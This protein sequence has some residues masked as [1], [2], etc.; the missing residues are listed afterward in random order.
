MRVMLASKALVVGAYHRKL[1]EI[2]SFPGIELIAVVPP[3]WRDPAYEQ[4]LERTAPM[5]YE[6]VVTPIAWNGNF[7]LF[8]YPRLGRLLTEYRPDIL[9]FDEE[10]YNLATFLALAQAR[11]R[12][13]PALF[14][15]WQNLNRRYP[16]PFAWM[17][18]FA[19]RTSSWAIAGTASAKRVL[20]TKGYRGPLTV[21]PQFGIDP[22]MYR[23]REGDPASPVLRIGFAGRLVVEKGVDLLVDAVAQMEQPSRLDI[24]GEGPAR[25]TIEERIRAHNLHDRIRLAGAVPSVE[26][27]RRLQELDVVVLPSISRPNW[28]EQFGRILVEAMASGLAVVGSTC[29]EI[30]EVIGDA[31]IVV[32]E[33]DVAALAG[34]FDRLARDPELRKRLGVAGRQRALD[35]YTHRRVAEATVEVYRAIKEL[36]ARRDS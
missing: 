5:G 12:Q 21:I 17:E 18:R 14:F 19:Y 15:S 23:A 24:L 16:P 28:E 35:H 2:A 6:L 26:M 36:S 10:P 7:H 22:D 27:P 8:F 1:E 34:A 25:S 11:R 33:G 9:H 32:P 31:G 13:I 20:E 30:P 4:R 3:S 29:G